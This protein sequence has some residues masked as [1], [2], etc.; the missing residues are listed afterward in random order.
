MRSRTLT[1]VRTGAGR[2]VSRPRCSVCDA[3]HRRLT[4]TG[5]PGIGPVETW[6]MG[7]FGE[8]RVVIFRDPDGIMLELTEHVPVET[9]RPP[10]DA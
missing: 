9:A 3:A 8:R 4:L 2:C 1:A 5:H 6:D 10:F 7:E